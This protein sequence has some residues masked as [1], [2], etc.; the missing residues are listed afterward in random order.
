MEVSGE[1]H[2]PATELQV[3]R[4]SFG[5]MEKG[6]CLLFAGD[7]FPAVQPV[8][9]RYSNQLTLIRCPVEPRPRHPLFWS[10][11]SLVHPGPG[12]IVP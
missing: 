6:K 8:A 5:A 3:P 11:F 4:A 2:A 12:G 1:L 10:W 7:R 9:R